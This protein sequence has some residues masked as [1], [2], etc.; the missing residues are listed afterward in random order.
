MLTVVLIHLDL[1]YLRCDSGLLFVVSVCFAPCAMWY[2]IRFVASLH[3]WSIICGVC[4]LCS[5]WYSIRSACL[6]AYIL[7]QYIWVIHLV[8]DYSSKKLEISTISEDN[9]SSIE[10][11]LHFGPIVFGI[12]YKNRVQNIGSGASLLP[13]ESPLCGVPSF[14]FSLAL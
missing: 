13:E 11:C 3:A 8:S 14:V 1:L 2:G 6:V 4:L 9:H 7:C 10:S 5:L 12:K